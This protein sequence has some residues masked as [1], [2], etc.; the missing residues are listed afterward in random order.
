MF[1]KFEERCKLGWKSAYAQLDWKYRHHHERL[2]RY[3]AAMPKK[4]LC[5]ECKGSGSFEIDRIDFHSILGN[6]GWCEGIGY[7]TPWIRGMWLRFKREEKKA[8]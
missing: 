2:K 7:V 3:I 4:L 1:D 8:A 6:C 5:Q